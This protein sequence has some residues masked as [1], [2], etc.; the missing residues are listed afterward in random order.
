MNKW[1][2]ALSM[3]LCMS[4][5]LACAK[6][7][8]L[9]LKDHLFYPAEIKV[10]ANKK[11]R[12][13]IEN[14]DDNDYFTLAQSRT[15]RG[16]GYKIA[17]KRF[18]CQETKHFFFNRVFSAWNSLAG[19]VVENESVATFKNGLDKYMTSNSEIRYFFPA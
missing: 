4:S 6:E 18:S 14:Q 3:L 7:Y 16:N 12:L 15:T 2:A 1:I 9:I 17:S 5:W 10:P 8:K 19:S 13:V 11:L